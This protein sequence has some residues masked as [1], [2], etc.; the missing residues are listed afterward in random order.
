MSTG[1]APNSVAPARMRQA[2]RLAAV[3]AILT[4]GLIAYGA[5]VRAS[6]SGLGCPD[7]PLCHGTVAPE[8]QKA[9]YIEWGHRLYAGLVIIVSSLALLSAYRG[10]EADRGTFRLLAAVIVVLLSQAALGGVVVLTELNNLAVMIH[11]ALA[12]TT[13]SLLILASMR[14]LAPRGGA[15]P[16]ASLVYT[17]LFVGAIVILLGSSLVATNV[18]ASCQAFPFCP[19]TTEGG[20]T[21]LHIAHRAAGGLLFFMLVVLSVRLS[22]IKAPAMLKAAGHTSGTAL[23][24]QG[25]VGILGVMWVFPEWIRI[26]HLGLAALIWA[27]LSVLW[28]AVL[29]SRR[30]Q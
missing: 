15:M 3:A 10:R 27:G 9:T 26:L 28:A 19:G 20:P 16:P 12:M 17:T 8:F 25:V 14:V 13:L 30:P 4:V 21:A 22:R 1:M 7:W 2:G 6:G 18:W 24:A 11:L 29:V 5:W 23:L